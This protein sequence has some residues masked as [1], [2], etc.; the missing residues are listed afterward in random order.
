M[1]DPQ[2]IAYRPNVGMTFEFCG[3]PYNS[4][5]CRSGPTRVL[6]FPAVVLPLK[7]LQPSARQQSHVLA[8]SRISD[9]SRGPTD[10]ITC[11]GQTG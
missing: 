3:G 4:P 6:A 11:L 5:K 7:D 9:S 10:E 1:S 2:P 8:W